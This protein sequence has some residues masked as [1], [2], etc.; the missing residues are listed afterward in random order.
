MIRWEGAWESPGYRFPRWKWC[1]W[2]FGD[3]GI[4]H[5]GDLAT[6]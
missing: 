2:Y 4:F 1:F 3:I 5:P 6:E